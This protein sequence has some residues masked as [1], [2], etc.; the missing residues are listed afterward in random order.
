VWNKLPTAVTQAVLELAL[1]TR[2]YRRGNWRSF[3]D[4]QRYFVSEVSVYRLRA[5]DLITNPAFILMKDAESF[6]DPTSASNQLWQTEFT[7]LRVL[8]C[9]WFYLLSDTGRPT[10]PPNSGPGPRSAA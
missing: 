10:S 8:G 1:E 7:Y 6:A 4:Q 9:R 3:V 2:R 5:H